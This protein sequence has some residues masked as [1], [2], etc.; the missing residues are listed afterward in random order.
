MVWLPGSPVLYPTGV[1]R[2]RDLLCEGPRASN[3]PKQSFQN[4]ALGLF[5]GLAPSLTRHRQDCSV[6]GES[7]LIIAPEKRLVPVLLPFLKINIFSGG[8][9]VTNFTIR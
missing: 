8:I 5:P 7:S 4:L 3:V 6:Q 9:H 1:L 2:P